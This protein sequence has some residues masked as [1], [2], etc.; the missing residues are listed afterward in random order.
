M[1]FINDFMSLM[2]PRHCEACG[3]DLFRHEHYL[4]NHCRVGLPR[5]N[6]HLENDNPLAR[7]FYGRVPFQLA[8]AFYLFEKSGKVQRLLHAIKY[9]EQKELA[10]HL[11]NIY[12]DDLLKSNY[13]GEVDI[14]VPVPLHPKKLRRRG[15]NQSE[16]FA[17]GLAHGLN[18]PLDPTSLIR[19]SDTGTQTRK[20]RYERWQN[21]KDIFSVADVQ[22]LS[23]M[24]VLLAD[25]VITTGATLEAAWQALKQCEGVKVS[26][27]SIAFAH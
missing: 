1:T 19:T 27:C 16:W 8:S 10:F 25:D 26:L 2:Y 14:I 15:F 20:K 5:S 17:K 23:G 13:F 4:C 21:V 18:K 6:Y 24:H 22:A 9:D 11:G 12:S 3:N 7:K